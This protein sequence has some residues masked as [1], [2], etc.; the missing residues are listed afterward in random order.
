MCKC[1]IP[2][3][4]F[5]VVISPSREGI[6]LLTE[7]PRVE[8]NHHVEGREVHQQKSFWLKVAKVKILSQR[9]LESSKVNIIF[10]E[11][12]RVKIVSQSTPELKLFSKVKNVL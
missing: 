9:A 10:P 12:P 11:C 8:V 7:F 2:I 5:K 4:P 6:W 3:S 1:E